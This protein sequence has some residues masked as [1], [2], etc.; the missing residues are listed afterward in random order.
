MRKNT[1]FVLT[2]F[3]RKNRSHIILS[4][5][6]ASP[7]SP[8]NSPAPSGEAMQWRCHWF[9]FSTLMIAHEKWTPLSYMM[10][11]QCNGGVIIDDSFRHWWLPMNTSLIYDNR[12]CKL[13]WRCHHW[14]QLSLFNIDD[15]SLLA[16]TWWIWGWRWQ[17]I[18]LPHFLQPRQKLWAGFV[19]HFLLRFSSGLSSAD[20]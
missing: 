17:L 8:S 18:H 4:P 12:I 6:F 20:I 2:S 9:Q 14:W 1:I 16:L 3:K 19:P 5:H 10:N 11:R 15:C 13:Q 7:P